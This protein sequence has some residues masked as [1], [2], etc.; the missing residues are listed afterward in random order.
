MIELP[1]PIQW[2]LVKQQSTVPPIAQFPLLSLTNWSSNNPLLPKSIIRTPKPFLP[3]F[4]A[5]WANP[6]AL[7]CTPLPGTTQTPRHP[8]TDS[9]D[10]A[11]EMTHQL[12]FLRRTRDFLQEAGGGQAGSNCAF[13]PTID[14]CV[15]FML[16]SAPAHLPPLPQ[17]HARK[18]GYFHLNETF[19]KLPIHYCLK[20]G[21][22]RKGEKLLIK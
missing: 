9:V 18:V 13:R 17:S 20:K 1:I 11:K 21:Q 3:G 7:H 14:I 15:A 2:A 16:P 19:A 8:S 5:Q 10:T 6:G 22:Q 12:S 4:P